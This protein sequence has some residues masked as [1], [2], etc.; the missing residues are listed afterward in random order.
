MGA[1]DT[2]GEALGLPS[3]LGRAILQKM[4]HSSLLFKA[5]IGPG[6]EGSIKLGFTFK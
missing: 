3:D 2:V 5:G 6:S 4:A 1:K